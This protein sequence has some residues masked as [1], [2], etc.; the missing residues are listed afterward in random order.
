MLSFDVGGQ[1]QKHG[2]AATDAI[3]GDDK[4]YADINVDGLFEKKIPGGG[5]VTAEGAYYHYNV[6]DGGV[7][8]S[9]LRARRPTPPRPSASATSSRWSA[10]SG[11][12]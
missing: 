12:R 2:S 7:S 10:T 8:D 3:D 9:L 5:W 1:F 6:L 4:T 11:R